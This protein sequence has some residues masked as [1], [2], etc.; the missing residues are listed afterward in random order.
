VECIALCTGKTT[1]MIQDSYLQKHYFHGTNWRIKSIDV[2]WM[3]RVSNYH[4]Q[5]KI[6]TDSAALKSINNLYKWKGLLPDPL[7]LSSG[8][9]YNPQY[10]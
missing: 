1:F 5:V 7:L 8:I 4:A 9:H 2:I 10:I 3:I 6:G